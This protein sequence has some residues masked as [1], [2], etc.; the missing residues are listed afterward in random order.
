MGSTL[1]RSFTKGVIWQVA[2]LII[3]Y[4]L[5]QS[6]Q[7]SLVYIL[8]RIVLYFLYERIWK[9]IKWGKIY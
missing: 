9:K 3:L 7:I 4:A 5:T 2:G 1:I 8:F 6:I